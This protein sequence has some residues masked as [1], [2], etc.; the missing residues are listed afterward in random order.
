MTVLIVEG[1]VYRRPGPNVSA[2]FFF[3]SVDGMSETGII[4]PGETIIGDSINR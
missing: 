1:G 4:S 3:L 2:L